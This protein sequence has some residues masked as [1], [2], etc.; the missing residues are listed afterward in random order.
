V[1]A[2]HRTT[3]PGFFPSHKLAAVRSGA[4]LYC[5]VDRRMAC[6]EPAHGRC[7]PTPRLFYNTTSPDAS[8]NYQHPTSYQHNLCRPTAGITRRT[9]KS[10]LSPTK[11]SQQ[12]G[13]VHAPVGQGWRPGL[14]LAKRPPIHQRLPSTNRPVNPAPHPKRQPASRSEVQV[15]FMPG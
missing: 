6:T 14:S 1:S 3:I 11:T 5:K 8:R 12:F 13:R 10:T 15:R 9:A 4:T 7:Q 2:T